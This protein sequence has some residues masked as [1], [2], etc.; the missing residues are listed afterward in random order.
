MQEL[1]KAGGSNIRVVALVEIGMGI[2]ADRSVPGR[3]YRDLRISLGTE[4]GGS[5][6]AALS[7]ATGTPDLAY[8]VARG[9][10]QLAAI[11]PSAFLIMAYRGTGPYA[12]ALPLRAVA[13]M[14]SWDRMAFAVF[15][16]TGLTSMEDIP[17]LRYPLRLSVRRNQSHGTR[18]VVDQALAAVGV[19][20]RDIESWG[21]SLQLVDAPSD[22]IRMDGIRDGSI[23]AV[24]DEGIKSWGRIG[25]DLGMTFLPLGPRVQGRFEQLGWPIGPIPANI[26]PKVGHDLPALSFSGWPIFTHA[27]LPEADAYRICAALDAARSSI[28]WDSP[29]EVSLSDLCQ[30]TDAAPRGIPLHPGAERYYREHGAID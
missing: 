14:P 29:S 12:E 5:F 9:E 15:P 2:L 20:L 27:D 18:F 4:S 13:T 6:N 10:I 24:F 26:F 30:D 25:L 7:F 3:P 19:T 21:G 17:R 16:K 22:Q 23:D 1:Q 28:A 11:N 8:G